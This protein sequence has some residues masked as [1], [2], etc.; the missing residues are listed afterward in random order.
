MT[1]N[2]EDALTVRVRKVADLVERLR[3]ENEELRASLKNARADVRI[4]Q[5]NRG[6][7]RQRVQRVIEMIGG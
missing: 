1:E 6:T 4:L 2:K 3:A 7:V 5:S